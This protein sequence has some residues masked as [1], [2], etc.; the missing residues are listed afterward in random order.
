MIQLIKKKLGGRVNRIQ[1]KR[2]GRVQASGASSG[3][4]PATVALALLSVL[5]LSDLGQAEVCAQLQG[6]LGGARPKN[7]VVRAGTGVLS[8]FYGPNLVS[9]PGKGAGDFA[10]Y[11]QVRLLQ[12]NVENH[13]PQKDAKE[14]MALSQLMKNESPELILVQEVDQ[15][16][17]M[18]DFQK[19]Y[20][21]SSYRVL[22]ID[23][24]DG[25]GIDSGL[26][27]KN[28]FPL[29]V[30]A[31]SFK[32]LADSDGPIFRRDAITFVFR[33][34]SSGLPL[35]AL[36][37]VHLKSMRDVPGDPQG[38]RQRAREV[39]G[40][41]LVYQEIQKAFGSQFPVLISGDFN[42]EVSTA[43]EFDPLRNWGFRD[44]LDLVQYPSPRHTHFYFTP[45]GRKLHRSFLQLDSTQVDLSAQ[46]MQLIQDARVLPQMDDRGQWLKD[47]QT[48]AEK[49]AAGRPSDHKASLIVLDASKIQS[50]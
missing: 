6:S 48:M 28:D 15:A 49:K 17:T 13:F 37:G 19:K 16:S 47:P 10:S 39:L 46:K 40:L 4:R 24:N 26:Y 5:L 38:T 45:M 27:V 20:L 32:N 41:G 31:Q 36:V 11:R 29:I 50:P 3:G 25:R 35:F 30:E 7:S 21:Q 33:N 12:W 1:V 43:P 18:E 9:L 8:S 42:N 14:L 2:D 44:A 22:L 34:P 23:G